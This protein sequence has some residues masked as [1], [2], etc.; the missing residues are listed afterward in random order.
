[1]APLAIGLVLVAAVCHATWN[2]LSKRLAGHDPVAITWTTAAC[3]T[4][5]VLPAAVIAWLVSHQRLDRIDV[6]FIAG[7][8]VLHVGY[9][10]TLQRGYGRGDLSLVYPLARG[11]GPLLSGLLA[12]AVYTEHPGATGIAGIALVA[13]G[14][15]GIGMPNGRRRD[16]DASRRA[17]V[18]YGLATGLLIAAYTLWDKHAVAYLAI[19]PLVY[20]WA[21]GFGRT[22]LLA[23]T[24]LGPRGR[25][26]RG[27]VAALWHDHAR[28]LVAIGV[29]SSLAYTLV[30]WALSFSPV[31]SIAPVREVSV[32]IGVLMGGRLLAEG[33][34]YRRLPAAAA[35]AAGVILIAVL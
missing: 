30:L 18:G 1:M 13:L 7:S 29:L 14:V 33:D 16:R 24:L 27:R 5:A 26:R 35:I 12:I 11:T 23:P 9:F 19:N 21:T 22:V 4:V 28:E 10:L 34:A 3:G 8:A 2:L 31:S 25:G 15:A 32:L 6:A 20:D 17:G